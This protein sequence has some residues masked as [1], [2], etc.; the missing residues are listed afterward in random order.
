MSGS[1]NCHCSGGDIETILHVLKDCK[2]TREVWLKILNPCDI[3]D[4]FVVDIYG[5]CLTCQA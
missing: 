3:D 1:L 2:W 5:C 4:S